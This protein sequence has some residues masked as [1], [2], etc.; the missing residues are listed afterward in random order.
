MTI[1]TM[2]INQLITALEVIKKEL[3]EKVKNTGDIPVLLSIDPEGNGFS[4][5]N[6]KWSFCYEPNSKMG[7]VLII[8]PYEEN[9]D[10]S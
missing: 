3:K 4:T 2:T 10:L 5:M 1:E 9:I 6:P 7:N 8:Y